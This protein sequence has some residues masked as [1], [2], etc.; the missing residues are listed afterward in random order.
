[1]HETGI[2]A[3]ILDIAKREAAQRGAAG[4]TAVTVRVGD[5]AGV[6]PEAL[7]FAFE[8]LCAGTN[9]AGARLVIE[10]VP[11]RARCRV[12]GRETEPEPDLVL[13]CAECGTPLEV[14][15]GQE[16]LVESLEIREP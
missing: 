11:M 7:E 10:R 6:A 16:L 13:W 4:I 8:A 9:A 5:L 3:E 2:A 1:M 12:C 15:A 14:L